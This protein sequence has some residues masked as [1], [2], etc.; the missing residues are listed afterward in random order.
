[1]VNEKLKI[2]FVIADGDEFEG[3]IVN[4]DQLEP[5]NER[6]AKA[7]NVEAIDS[8]YE[9]VVSGDFEI[10]VDDPSEYTGYAVVTKVQLTYI[11]G[12]ETVTLDL[13]DKDY[14]RDFLEHRLNQNFDWASYFANYNEGKADLAYESWLDSQYED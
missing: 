10:E 6:A 4:F 5:F 9:I 8:T 13:T 7:L 11:K 1:M 2:G 12:N 3:D 14:D